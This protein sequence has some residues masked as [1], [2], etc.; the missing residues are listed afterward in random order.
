M[1]KIFINELETEKRNK[2]IKNNQKLINKLQADLYESNMDMQYINSKDII[3]DEALRSIE[4]HDNYNSFFYTLKNWR[5]FI[6]NIDKDYLSSDAEKIYNHIMEKI[7]T[8]DNMDSYGEQYYK[9]EEHLENE[10]KEVLKDIEDYLHEY[11]EYPS[12][13][14]AIEYADEMEQLNDYYIEERDDGTSDG[15][16]RQDIAYTETFI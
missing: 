1:K 5:K 11:E 4:Y 10:T 8:L 15:V 14:D 3:N 16:I 2:L 13:D 6:T 12:E 9:L 7:E